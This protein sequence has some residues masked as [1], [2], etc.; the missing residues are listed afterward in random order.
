MRALALAAALALG[1]CA[2]GSAVE[3]TCD[4]DRGCPAGSHCLRGTGVCVRFLTPLD[5]GGGADLADGGAG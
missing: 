4:D 1:G 5:D 2:R 3:A